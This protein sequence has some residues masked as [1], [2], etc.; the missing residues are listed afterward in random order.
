LE[1]IIREWPSREERIELAGHWHVLATITAT[2]LLFYFADMMGIK[3]KARKWFG[4]TVI[5]SSNL[6]FGAAVILFLKRIFVSEYAQQAMVDTIYLAIEIGL[7][8]LLISL[9]V[10]MLWR[11]VDLFKKKGHWEAELIEE[12]QEAKK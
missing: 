6:A 4:W 1:E 3:G 7:G 8:T 2:I 11:L 12:Q 9:A 5:L 10:F